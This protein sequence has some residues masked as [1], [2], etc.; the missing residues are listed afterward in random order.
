[1][2]KNTPDK[3]AEINNEIDQLRHILYGNQAR[4]TEQRIDTLEA[5]LESVNKDLQ[6]SLNE[7]AAT[8][9]GAA[10]KQFQTLEAEL[11][12]AKSNFNQRLEQQIN[13]L[14]QQLAD[15]RAESR[16]RDNELRQ[17]MLTLGAMLDKQ[18][19]GRVEL[20]QLL[21]DL[22]QQLQENAQDTA[23]NDSSS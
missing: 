18:K 10:A 8:L 11:A 13:D 9:S 15:F 19:T 3:K 7:Q 23:V 1:M 6:N 14:R 20:G 17:E 2:S 21:V 4:A 12:Q 5:R 16:Q 22:G